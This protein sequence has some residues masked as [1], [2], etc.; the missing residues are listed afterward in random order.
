MTTGRI[1]QVTNMPKLLSDRL[2]SFT[3]IVSNDRSV[4]RTR[5]G[6][7]RCA[8]L[9]FLTCNQLVRGKINAGKKSFSGV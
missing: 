1:N 5:F 8:I 7:A 9:D 6:A 2:I 3:K 4:G